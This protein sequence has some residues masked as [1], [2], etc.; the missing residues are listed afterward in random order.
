MLKSKLVALA[1]ASVTALAAAPSAHAATD[2]FM[3]LDPG[4]G[5]QQQILGESQDATF[6]GNKGYIDIKSF[7]WGIEN[8]TT[9]GSMSGGAGSGKAKLNELTVEKAV[10][11]TTPQLLQRVGQ[12]QHFAGV[13]IIA[14]KAGVTGKAAPSPTRYYFSLA[15]PTSLEQSGDGG[16]DVLTEKLTFAYGAVAQKVLRQ[17]ANGSPGTSVFGSWNQVLNTATIDALP[18]D[19][20]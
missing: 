17:A 14:R 2:Y 20:K 4:P 12:G 13:E 7:N 11:S 15:F 19:M 5:D 16:D 9:I 8:P 3:R 6:P 1:V 18:S 10:D